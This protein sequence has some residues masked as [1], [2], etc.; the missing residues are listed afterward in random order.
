MAS[1]RVPHRGS[2]G[3]GVNSAELQG[4]SRQQAAG[5]HAMQDEQWVE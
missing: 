5:Q 4:H 3:S 2:G 1:A